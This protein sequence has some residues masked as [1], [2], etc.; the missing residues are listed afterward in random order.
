ML[1]EIRFNL[2]HQLGLRARAESP[3]EWA[4]RVVGAA[5]SDAVKAESSLADQDEQ[6]ESSELSEE[7]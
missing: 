7:M 2:T 6:A 5:L 4:E 1:E 3:H